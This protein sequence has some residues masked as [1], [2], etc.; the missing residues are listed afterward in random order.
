MEGTRTQALGHQGGVTVP[1]PGCVT[2]QHLGV[3][4]GPQ[5]QV[6][7]VL[8]SLTLSRCQGAVGN[9]DAES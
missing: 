4:W 9:C 1:T 7:V 2:H 3:L 8:G 6:L 5:M